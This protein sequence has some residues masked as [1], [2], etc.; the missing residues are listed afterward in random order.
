MAE[1]LDSELWLQKVYKQ[2]KKSIVN[3]LIQNFGVR[4]FSFSRFLFWFSSTLPISVCRE[5]YFSVLRSCVTL[6][7]RL[8]CVYSFVKEFG[9]AFCPITNP[10][11]WVFTKF[12]KAFLVFAFCIVYYYVFDCDVRRYRICFSNQFRWYCLRYE[13]SMS[14][15]K[16]PLHSSEPNVQKLSN[17][18]IEYVFQIDSKSWRNCVVMKL[19]ESPEFEALNTALC[20]DCGDIKIVGRYTD[21]HITIRST[22][23]NLFKYLILFVWCYRIE[24]YSCKMIG[25]EKQMY[26]KFNTE[27]GK[28]PNDLYALSPPQ[29][30]GVSPVR[31]GSI[32]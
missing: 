16:M 14:E 13:V 10:A 1:L 3:Q 5:S 32:R 6:V 15:Q 8:C 18:Q 20:L 19:L 9:V 21:S 30:L 11:F 12:E 31:S 17:F 7:V 27:Q 24:G 22:G 4:L 29:Q 26:K 28:N 23:S 2:Q 25:N